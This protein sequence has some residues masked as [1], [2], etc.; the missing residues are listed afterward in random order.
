MFVTDECYVPPRDCFGL[1]GLFWLCL[2]FCQGKL[3]SSFSVLRLNSPGVHWSKAG[4]CWRFIRLGS[5]P[6]MS[7]EEKWWRESKAGMLPN[8]LDF[9]LE[10]SC[11]TILLE[12]LL[13]WQIPLSSLFGD[14]TITNKP[15]CSRLRLSDLYHTHFSCQA[16]G[17]I[18]CVC[19]CTLTYTAVSHY[20]AFCLSIF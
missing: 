9:C 17:W 7:F 16:E 8:N 4:A 6:S 20:S 11:E 15:F 10:H 12:K 2:H 19:L 5:V 3:G 14:F 18:P 13:D 1:G